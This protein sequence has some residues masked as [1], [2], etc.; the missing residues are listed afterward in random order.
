MEI[1][2]QHGLLS[3]A[4]REFQAT[5]FEQSHPGFPRLCSKHCGSVISK[6]LRGGIRAEEFRP[7]SS[8][9]AMDFLTFGETKHGQPHKLWT[10]VVLCAVNIDEG[11]FGRSRSKRFLLGADRQLSRQLAKE[12]H[13]FK[14]IVCHV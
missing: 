9:R 12:S 3:R 7:A 4:H 14:V 1:S 8:E 11:K 2:N 13:K 5:C 6:S 10:P